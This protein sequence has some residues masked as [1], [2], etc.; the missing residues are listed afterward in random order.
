MEPERREEMDL[1]SIMKLYQPAETK[2]EVVKVR[3]KLKIP[4]VVVDTPKVVAENESQKPKETETLKRKPGRPKKV[5]VVT[6]KVKAETE[7]DTPKED[8]AK[9]LE[10]LTDVI[11]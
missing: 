8:E 4:K 10:H 5:V 2:P 9:Q 7:P 3:P 6:P 1:D 11:K